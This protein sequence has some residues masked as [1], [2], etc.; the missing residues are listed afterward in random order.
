MWLLL[1]CGCFP[2]RSMPLGEPVA[3]KPAKCPVRQERV[4]Q[5]EAEA[6]YAQVGV[7][8][9]G[10]LLAGGARPK[11]DTMDEVERQN[12]N[13]EVCGLGGEIVVATG[14]C[15]IGKLDGVEWRVYRERPQ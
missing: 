2:M 12:F 5:T 14:L 6:Q 3:A 9:E 4:T 11:L 10:S 1:L 15:S 7:I 13:E 8:C